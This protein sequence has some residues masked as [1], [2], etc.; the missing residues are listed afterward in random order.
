MQGH[1]QACC[2]INETGLQQNQ[3]VHKNVYIFFVYSLTFSFVMDDVCLRFR[4]SQINLPEH[5]PLG[6]WKFDY[7]KIVHFNRQTI[8]ELFYT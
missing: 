2:C 1:S 5:M 3:I 8:K 7:C 6:S 4:P